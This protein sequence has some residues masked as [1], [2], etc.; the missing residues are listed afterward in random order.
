MSLQQQPSARGTAA[1]QSPR[2]F[3]LVEL[4]VVITII[5][6]LIALLLPAVQ[7]ARESARR[8]QCSNNLKQLG[9]GALQHVEKHRYFPTGGWGYCWV[10]DPDRG[11]GRRQPGGWIYNILPYIDQEALHQLGKGKAA[12]AKRADAATVLKT[13]LAILNCPTRRQTM[14]YPYTGSQPRNADAVSMTA[15][16]DYA[17]C[18]GNDAWFELPGPNASDIP[19]I[20]AGTYT[21]TYVNQSGVCFQASEV[22]PDQ[23]K[24]GMTLTILIGEKY[25]NPDWYFTGQDGGDNETMYSGPNVDT[26]RSTNCNPSAGLNRVPM[27]DRPGLRR[28][29]EYGSAHSGT[30]GFVFCDGSVRAISYSIDP[31]TFDSLGSRKDGMAIDEALFQ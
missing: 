26:I 15:K 19:A 6:I 13:P 2:A 8:T 11:F 12:A 1:G 27:Q 7:T 29:W 25:M 28:P 23:I 16:N 9:L 17:A 21:W 3:T 20:D 18:C 4:L 5:G 14:L 22:Q 10:G 30:C 24:D 31:A